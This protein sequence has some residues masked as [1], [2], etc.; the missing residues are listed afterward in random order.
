MEQGEKHCQCCL[1][2]IPVLIHLPIHLPGKRCFWCFSK[3]RQSVDWQ[4]GASGQTEISLVN[5]KGQK[6]L[7]H[8]YLLQTYY[9]F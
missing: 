9:D 6:A 1:L 7:S 8:L 2:A 4:L 3:D 5:S